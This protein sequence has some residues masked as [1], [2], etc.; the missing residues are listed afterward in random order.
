MPSNHLILC[1]LL[2]LLPSV[3]PASGYFPMSQFF[4]SGGQSIEASAS[5]SVLPM[6][7]QGWFP[8][9][10][11][12]SQGILQYHSG[13]ASVL[14]CSAFFMVQLSHP[15]IL[16]IVNS[17]SV[18]IGVHVSFSIMV[19]SGY[20]PS[21]GIAGSY[22]SFACIQAKLLQPCPTLCNPIDCN[23]PGS[24]VHGILQASILEWVSMP[25]S[26]GSSQPRDWIRISCISS[27]GRPVLYQ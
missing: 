8:C 10:P 20:M 6:N 1:H 14:W 21:S 11:R 18:N 23:P 24:S 2:L 9:C 13:K 12:D 4:A 3:F 26:R 27:V 25:S 15:Y 17:T 22:N 19:S 7:I 5:E 16:V